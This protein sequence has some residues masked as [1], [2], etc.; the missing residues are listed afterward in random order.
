VIAADDAL[1]L[2]AQDLVEIVGADGHEGAGGIRRRPA[3]GAIVVGDEPFGEVAIGVGHR[4]DA[5]HPQ[6]VDEA[7]LQSAVARGARRS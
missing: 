6:F 3:E 5:G 4:A 2:V 1:F 7:A